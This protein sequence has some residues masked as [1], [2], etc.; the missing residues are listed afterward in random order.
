[1][2]L[3][4]PSPRLLYFL[5]NHWIIQRNLFNVE[6]ARYC[7]TLSEFRKMKSWIYSNNGG[8]ISRISSKISETNSDLLK[9]NYINELRKR[10]VNFVKWSHKKIAIFVNRLQKKLPNFAKR[11]RENA[12]IPSNNYGKKYQILWVGHGRISQIS[13]KKRE[14]PLPPPKK[15]RILSN[16]RW[17]K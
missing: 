15:T 7:F 16:D 9:K 4:S 3:L 6:E 11:S 13:S 10:I 8:K 1:M 17:R 2:K 12:R 14:P 5:Q